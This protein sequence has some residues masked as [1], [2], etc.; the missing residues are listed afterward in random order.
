MERYLEIG[1]ENLKHNISL[2]FLVSVLLLLLSPL[3]LGVENLPAGDTA[4]VLEMYIALIGIIMLTPVFLPEQNKDLRDLVYSKYVKSASIY[5]I[6]IIQSAFIL[7][8]LLALYIAMLHYNNCQME[9]WKYFFGTFAEMMFFGALG[10]FF[11]GLFDNLIIGYLIPAF[12]YIF[13]V[14]GG[15]KY[16]GVFYPFGMAGG[17]YK[18]KLYLAGAAI[19][20]LVLGIVLRCRRK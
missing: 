20:L 12:Y 16:L 3:V 6:R 8:L 5:I 9:I 2:H 1:K 15:V 19:V 11:Y 14:G 13:A 17:S 4:K 7:L 18:E 10:I